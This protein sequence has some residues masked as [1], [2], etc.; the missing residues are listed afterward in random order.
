MTPERW[1][2]VKRAL[3]E[4][5]ALDA[6]SRR[7]YLERIG[8]SDPELGSEVE[9]LLNH[10]L[11]AAS[12]FLMQQLPHSP[13]AQASPIPSR[14]GSR[15]GV[16]QLR[17]EIGHGGMGSVYRAARADGHYE[18]QV[19]LKFV[20]SGYDTTSVLERFRHERQILASLDHPNIARLLDGGTTEDGIPYLVMELIEGTRVDEYCNQHPLSVTERLEIFRQVCSA[21]QYAHQRLVIHRD[22]KPGNIL[23][24]VTGVPKLLDFGIAKIFDP[25][26]PSETTI[27][28]PL[29]PEYASPEQIR[30]EPITT[31]TDVYSLGV[32]L[33]RLLTSRSPYRVDTH[34]PVEFARAVTETEPQR[35][36]TVVAGSDGISSS[37]SLS[38]REDSPARLGRRLRGDL[39]NIVLMTLRKEPQRRYSSV[40]QL[41]EDIRRHLDG[42]PVMARRGSWSYRTGKLVRRNKAAA[43]AVALVVLAVV[44]G[45]AATVHQARIARANALRAERRFNDVRSLANSLIFD[46]HDSIKDLPGSTPARKVI[47]DRALQYLNVLAQEPAG[48]VGLERELATAYE[49]VGTVQGDYLQN[50][51]GD[52]EGALA[53]YKRALA[54]RK[55]VDVQSPDWNDHLG[56]AQSYRL[57]AHQLWATGDLNGARDHIDHA[58][59]ISGALDPLHPNT[60]KILYEVA[61]DHEVSGEIRYRGDRFE[62]QKVIE[63]YRKALAADEA[64][65]KIQP[66][67]VHSLHGYAVDLR[68]TGDL[69]EPTDPRAALPYYEKA[70]EINRKLTQRSTE[71]Q[72]ARSVAIS[73]GEIADVYA[74]IGDYAREAENNRKGL[75]IYQDLC[76][77]DP[78][79]ALLRQGLAIAYVNTA[80]AVARVGNTKESLEYSSRGLEIM[81]S[82]VASAPQNAV[83]K[84]I[85]AAMLAARGTILN[86]SGKPDAAISELD[87]AR[88]IYESLSKAG[89]GDQQTNIAACDVE[90]GK[91]A[92][93]AGR[94][95]EAAGYFGQALRIVKPL[96]A[97]EAADLDALYTAADAYLGLGELSRKKA[98]RTNQTGVGRESH[99]IEARSWYEQSLGTWRRIEHPNRTSPNG[100]QVGD[101]AIVAKKLK[102]TEAALAHLH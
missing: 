66:D 29:T 82:L 37:A 51:L 75:E 85:F 8:S 44:G 89:S 2:Q 11:Q 12:G 20:R 63:D 68:N 14:T 31:A 47:V 18:K 17:E 95:A 78:K 100:F 86:A 9:T 69:L 83:Q 30:G 3:D 97:N 72:Y 70:L 43:A 16:Y 74:D 49:K 102:A 57:V 7:P 13:S 42:L 40:E 73:Y 99:W 48:D 22:I 71:I 59:A 24:T 84:G 36:S 39:D 58:I 98:E 79:N 33:Y 32:V 67:D 19:A 90:L 26:G 91:A 50:N 101:P 76:R 21:V 35:P 61:F 87:S 5:I 1:Q 92:T 27:L 46:V 94:D 10:H 38:H 93:Q 60:A 28:H 54:I 34:S 15:V 81:R 56:L 80:T 52:T 96:V 41:Q 45:V 4:A 88:S 64:T 25:A 77:A 23:V 55:R 65:L 6:A 62:S 53:S